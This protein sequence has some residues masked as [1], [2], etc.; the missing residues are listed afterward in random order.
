[1]PRRSRRRLI[2]TSSLLHSRAASFC[3]PAPAARKRSNP[4]S[5]ESRRLAGRQPTTARIAVRRASQS[6]RVTCLQSRR[7]VRRARGTTVTRETL[8]NTGPAESA[9]VKPKRRATDHVVRCLG[10]V[11]WT[12]PP[13]ERHA[14][15]LSGTYNA[16]G[17]LVCLTAG[18][19]LLA[20]VDLFGVLFLAAS[21][22]FA[23]DAY[24]N[25]RAGH[26]SWW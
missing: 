16:L 1:M 23:R 13:R 9:T 4:T 3:S 18:I 10:R 2:T 15:G 5:S 26:W 8:R 12:S 25:Y 7:A 20:H 24:L 14:K 6:Q 19:A 21:A 17:A 11:S 22:V